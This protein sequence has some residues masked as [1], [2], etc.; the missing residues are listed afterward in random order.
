M[1]IAAVV[2]THSPQ[3]QTTLQDALGRM[4]PLLDIRAVDFDKIAATMELPSEELTSFLKKIAALPEA[5][6]LELVFV[7][8]EDDLDEDGFIPTPPEARKYD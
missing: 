7:N 4:G 8:Y 1:A 6:N 3:D 2:I 5:L